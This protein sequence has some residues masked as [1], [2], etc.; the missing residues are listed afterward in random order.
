[1]AAERGLDMPSDTDGTGR[2]ERTASDGNLA[3]GDRVWSGPEA[4]F[5]NG[6]G[7]DT[8]RDAAIAIDAG[9]IAWI[10]RERE[11]SGQCEGDHRSG[12]IALWFLGSLTRIPMR[13]GR[14]IGWPTLKHG[15]LARPTKR[16]SLQA[17]ASG[18][19]SVETADKSSEEMAALALPRIE[20]LVQSGATTIEVKSGYGYS[21]EA[22]LRM[23][24]AIRLLQT[25]TQSQAGTYAADSHLP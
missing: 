21:P 15:A 1:M 11:W 2:D 24:E 23:L 13:S 7:A 16:F 3:V 17:A 25:Q 6:N 5:G 22:E 20:A 4:W 18:I 10:G 8:L 12:W 14:E 19:P 9:R